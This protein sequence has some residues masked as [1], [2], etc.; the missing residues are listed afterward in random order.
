M[1]RLSKWLRFALQLAAFLMVVGLLWGMS[2]LRTDRLADRLTADVLA[3]QTDISGAPGQ[4]GALAAGPSVAFAVG[5]AIS[6]CKLPGNPTRRKTVLRPYAQLS[7]GAGA[8][9]RR[10]FRAPF[11]C[12]R[13]SGDAHSWLGNLS[14]ALRAVGHERM[15]RDWFR[16]ES[17]RPG[18]STF[19]GGRKCPRGAENLRRS[20]CVGS[21]CPVQYRSPR[22]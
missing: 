14:I 11:G 7:R 21:K 8:F 9:T 12:S 16:G 4:F 18:A 19:V 2:R 5:G 22:C 20:L 17:G 10:F 6:R 15:G 3:L 13:S 1:N